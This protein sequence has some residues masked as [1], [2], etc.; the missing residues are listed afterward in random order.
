M[1]S[2]QTPYVLGELAAYLIISPV[3]GS[4]LL[5]LAGWRAAGPRAG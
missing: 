2:G 1:E 4:L 3:V 5:L